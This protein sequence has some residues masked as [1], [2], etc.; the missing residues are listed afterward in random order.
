MFLIT[1]FH[2]YVRTIKNQMVSIV[3]KPDSH[4]TRLNQVKYI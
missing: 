2:L 1:D 4:T 3:K